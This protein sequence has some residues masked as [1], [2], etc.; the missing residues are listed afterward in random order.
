MSIFSKQINKIIYDDIIELNEEKMREN[1]RLE[2]KANVPNKEETIKKISSIANTY[3]GYIVIGASD[4]GNGNLKSLD[5]VDPQKSLN[6]KIIQWCYDNIYPPVTPFISNAISHKVNPQKVF[7][8]IFIE[9]SHETPHFLNGRKGCYIR[10]DE[11][12]QRFNPKLATY[13]EIQHLSNRRKQAIQFR[14]SLIDRSQKRF[15]TH[16]K[17]H[18]SSSKSI[19]GNIDVT[20]KLLVSPRFL[21]LYPIRI[22]ELENALIS[23]KTVARGIE[24][25]SGAIQSQHEGYYFLNPRGVIFSYLEA[26]IHRF[27]YYAQEMGEVNL[28]SN[29]ESKGGYKPQDVVVFSTWILAQIIFYLRYS[30][31]FYQNIGYNGSLLIQVELERIRGRQF[32]IPK[33]HGAT[34]YYRTSPQLDDSFCLSREI[35]TNKLYLNLWSLV[36]D[37][38]RNICFACGWRDAFS[39]NDKFID[40]NIDEALKYLMWQT[41]EKLP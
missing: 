40:G 1:I 39:V 8:V 36:K 31:K 14:T 22:V 3:G 27:I 9:E 10:T 15:E 6:Q 20:F 35:F 28:G 24:F 29:K 11:F 19:V 4:D 41:K 21:G 18:Y 13:E 34:G 30:Q 12:S 25:P 26:N 17:L 16:T 7:Y 37:I 38:Y 32:Y 5:G 23:S 33:N 2:Y